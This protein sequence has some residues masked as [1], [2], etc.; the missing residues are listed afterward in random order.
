MSSEELTMMHSSTGNLPTGNYRISNQHNMGANQNNWNKATQPE[1][2]HANNIPKHTASPPWCP[3][4]FTGRA[5]SFHGI[6]LI[7][8]VA[9]L[10]H[11]PS[12]E[13]QHRQDDTE[14]VEEGDSMSV[15]AY[16]HEIK[17]HCKLL[18]SI[19]ATAQARF[20]SQHQ[21][22]RFKLGS[23]PQVDTLPLE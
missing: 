12:T 4:E 11:R 14:R 10:T 9:T 20:L 5:S 1:G 13:T 2:K 19:S 15:C 6:L 17:S 18:R 3:E 7:H 23:P 22:S 16:A 8:P 21:F